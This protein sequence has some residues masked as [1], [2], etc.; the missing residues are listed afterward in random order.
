MTKVQLRRFA[1]L[2]LADFDCRAP[3]RLFRQPLELT[4][5]QAYELQEEV[6]R[7]R[8]QRGENIIGYKIGCISGTIQ[9]QLGIREPIFGRVF[10]SG[11]FSSGVGLSCS[12][13]ANLAIEGEWAVR[14][15][16]DLPG[17]PLSDEEY[18]PAIEAM[19]PVIELHHYVL[20]SASCAEL[21]AS[22]GMHAGLVLSEEEALTS[23]RPESARGL[24]VWIN[25]VKVGSVVEAGTIAGP[26]ASLRWLAARL[27]RFGLRLLR[28]QLIL[29]G[30]P[31]G[32]YPVTPGS[33][34]VVDAGPLGRSCAE[35]DP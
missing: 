35:I 7:L 20:Y 25:A 18:V 27:A 32:L 9:E 2:Q 19:F 14:L 16:R 3:G 1:V 11:C 21:I 29:T 6:A 15:A 10:Q 24:S 22:N 31:M 8:E 13:Y 30:S 17:K 34:I 33:L 23:G 26:I 4:T 12:D 5:Q 28:G